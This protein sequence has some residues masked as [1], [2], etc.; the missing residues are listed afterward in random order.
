MVIALCMASN[1]A[2]FH[3]LI[4]PKAIL[5]IIPPLSTDFVIITDMGSSYEMSRQGLSFVFCF[6]FSFFFRNLH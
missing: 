2:V 4:T 3:Q 5:C 6:L 1:L